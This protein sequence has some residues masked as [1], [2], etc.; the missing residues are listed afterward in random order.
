MKMYEK[1]ELK[2]SFIN[3]VNKMA[4]SYKT[5]TAYYILPLQS[6]SLYCSSLGAAI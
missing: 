1:I 5:R 6:V 2:Y 4:S 3:C